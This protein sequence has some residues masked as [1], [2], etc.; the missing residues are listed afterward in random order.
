MGTCGSDM[1]VCSRVRCQIVVFSLCYSDGCAAVSM[2]LKVCGVT[3]VIGHKHE[4]VRDY[5]LRD[6]AV[7][8]AGVIDLHVLIDQETDRVT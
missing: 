4:R 7:T 5:T 3:C 8:N 1:P 2:C 6:G